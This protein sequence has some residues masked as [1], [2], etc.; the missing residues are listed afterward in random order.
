[1]HVKS[2]KVFCDVVRRRSFS[3]AADENGISQSG[4]SQIVH[5]LEDHLAVKLIDRSKRPFVLTPEGEAYYQGCRKLV[6][7]YYALEEEVRTLHEDVAGRVS[8]A[9]IYSV[10]LS[11]MSQIVQDFLRRYP[12]ANVHLQ[13][14]HPD[15]VY[16]LVRNNAVDLGLVSYPRDSR[17]LR[18]IAWRQEPM[19][20]VVAP[21][22]ALAGSG[23]VRLSELDGLDFVG[24]DENLRI[25]HETDKALAAAH[26]AVRIVMEFDNI[27]TLKRAVEINAGVSLLPEPT[28]AREVAA[29]T[30]VALKPLE[31]ELHRPLGILC[32]RGVELG[33]TARRF[34][35]LLREEAAGVTAGGSNGR[36]ES[37]WAPPSRPAE[38]GGQVVVERAGILRGA[39]Q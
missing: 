27:E 14:Q 12:K 4:A 39:N 21:G 26:V 29:G 3:R 8:V 38:S 32:R 6:Q 19:V 2:L 9:S 24:F 5:H 31:V 18:V 1:M 10:G 16:E 30:L 20:V 13:Y 11:H 22:H 7:R 23:S 33:K 28:V 25:R 36:P 35:A 17:W 34:I 15:R 37:G